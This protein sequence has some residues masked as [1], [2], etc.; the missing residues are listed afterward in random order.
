[1]LLN[2]SLSAPFPGQR[3]LL[4]TQGQALSPG[5]WPLAPGPWPLPPFLPPSLLCPSLPASLTPCLTPSLQFLPPSSLLSLSL[6]SSIAHEGPCPIAYQLPSEQFST[7]RCWLWLSARCWLWLSQSWLR[8]Q[9]QEIPRL[10]PFSSSWLLLSP[11]DSCSRS[12]WPSFWLF[13]WVL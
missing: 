3:R 6:Y 2:R 7:A 8:T 12:F 4:R 13:P 5:P 10:A 9:R 11:P 1:M